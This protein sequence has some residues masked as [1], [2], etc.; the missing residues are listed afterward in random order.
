MLLNE[1]KLFFILIF[2]LIIQGLPFVKY[3]KKDTIYLEKVI[4][5]FSISLFIWSIFSSIGFV[6]QLNVSVLGK[7]W[8]IFNISSFL[9][10][11]Y[12]IKILLPSKI[13][14]IFKNLN[15]ILLTS[16]IFLLV[17]WK[18]AYQDG[19]SWVHVA[20]ANH[21]LHQPLLISESA[22]YSGTNAGSVYDYN[23]WHTLLAVIT[24]IGNFDS[25]RFVWINFNSFLAIIF[26]L[27]LY[28]FLQKYFNNAKYSFF[29]IIFIISINFIIYKF[30]FFGSLV[31]NGGITSR[32][33]IPIFFTFLFDKKSNIFFLPILLF[34]ISSFHIY[35][36]LK[37]LFMFSVFSLFILY[38]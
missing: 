34:S 13:K 36:Y 38:R 24:N 3:I 33:L 35:F 19:D 2:F 14:L 9:L 16:F 11:L 1:L 12:Q 10:Y 30:L 26:I 4:I 22:F 25:V 17:F 6:F 18:G 27:S 20:Q 28:L 15:I 8:L 32:I 23:A 29:S 31:T 21:Y 7:T 5:G 37:I